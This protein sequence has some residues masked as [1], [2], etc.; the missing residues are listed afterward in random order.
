MS[1]YIL[2]VLQIIHL[3]QNGEDPLH[4]QRITIACKLNPSLGFLCSQP[5][6]CL[7]S[8]NP[9]QFCLYILISHKSHSQPHQIIALGTSV[10]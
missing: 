5:D 2:Y 7:A 1:F 4:Q 6:C 9:I 3:I 8:P 10:V